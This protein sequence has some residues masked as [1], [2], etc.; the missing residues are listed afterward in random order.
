MTKKMRIAYVHSVSG[1]RE[2][3]KTVSGIQDWNPPMRPPLMPNKILSHF[4]GP[5]NIEN[6]SAK[7]RLK[8][9]VKVV[10]DEVEVQST[11]LVNMCPMI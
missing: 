4:H 5:M 2:S 9:L 7:F 3:H 8:F 6:D 1:I 11:Y 10:F